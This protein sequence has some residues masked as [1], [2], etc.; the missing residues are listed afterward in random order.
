M[1]IRAHHFI[2]RTEL[3]SSTIVSF[4]FCDRWEAGKSDAPKV[5]KALPHFIPNGISIHL[6][7]DFQE[8][9]T[10]VGVFRH[11]GTFRPVLGF[12]QTYLK[13]EVFVKVTAASNRTV[14]SL[15]RCMF[16]VLPSFCKVC[17]VGNH[18]TRKVSLSVPVCLWRD[19]GLAKNIL[20]VI[21]MVGTHPVMIVCLARPINWVQTSS[22]SR[23][24]Q[25]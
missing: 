1:C 3:Y 4:C 6:S 11:T 10:R 14:K 20:K 22:K 15:H 16:G 18:I 5:D 24:E 17:P 13:T 9:L 23:C 8:L 2:A 7:V 21:T 25:T 19:E 12:L